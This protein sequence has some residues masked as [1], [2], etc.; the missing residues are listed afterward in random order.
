MQWMIVKTRWLSLKARIVN[1]DGWRES[2]NATVR[3]LAII[4]ISVVIA[5]SFIALAKVFRV[6]ETAQTG[7]DVAVLAGAQTLIDSYGASESMN[8]CGTVSD[9]ASS[10][11][12]RIDWCGVQNLDVLSTS[13]VTTKVGPFPITF[14]VRARAGID[15]SRA[16]LTFVQ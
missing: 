9:L 5:L 6:V 11:G 13:S 10:N 1:E 7:L 15:E 16:H 3:A 14:T 8:V 4:F 12:L 2:G